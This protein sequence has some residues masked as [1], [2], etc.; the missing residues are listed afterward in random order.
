MASLNKVLLMGNLTRDPELRYIQSGT[1]VLE[2]ALAVNRRTK[3]KDG[4]WGDE[5][6][7]VDVTVWGKTAENCAEYLSKGRPV[8]VEG[9]L[10]LDQWDDKKT[11]EKRRKLKVTGENVQFLGSRGGSGGG[12]SPDRSRPSPPPGRSE[13]SGDMELS[14]DDIPF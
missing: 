4:S 8:F 14:D 6:T 9:H 5:A 11:G 7:Y 1:A 13:P 10:Q 2:L 12:S 3:Q